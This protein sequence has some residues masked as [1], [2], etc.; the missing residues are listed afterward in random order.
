VEEGE[1][2]EEND[3]DDERGRVVTNTYL[4]KLA[5]LPYGAVRPTYI[6]LLHNHT[7]HYR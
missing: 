1:E 3:D 4:A 7:A 5:Q 2:E 6:L